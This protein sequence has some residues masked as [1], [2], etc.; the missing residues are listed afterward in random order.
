MIFKVG[1][2]QKQHFPLNVLKNLMF[3]YF[4]ETNWENT[5][6]KYN[7]KHGKNIFKKAFC[8]Y[9]YKGPTNNLLT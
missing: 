4:G 9:V 7:T 8:S 6:K 5:L 2:K 1:E 3:R